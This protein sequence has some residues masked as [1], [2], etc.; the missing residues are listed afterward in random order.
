MSC[1]KVDGCGGK[2]RRLMGKRKKGDWGERFVYVRKRCNGKSLRC[3]RGNNQ[4]KRRSFFSSPCPEMCLEF[5][6]M[7]ALEA[8]NTGNCEQSM[9]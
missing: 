6:D 7:P 3:Q 9:G 5:A 8:T 2:D 4:S 1:K